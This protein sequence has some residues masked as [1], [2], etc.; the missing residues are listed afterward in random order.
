MAQG[1]AARFDAKPS[2]VQSVIASGE[3]SNETV[4]VPALRRF[5]VRELAVCAA[6]LACAL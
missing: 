2:L 5:G 1:L 3:P 4:Y 6:Q